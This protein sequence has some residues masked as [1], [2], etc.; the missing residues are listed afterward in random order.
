MNRSEANK[1]AS[2]WSGFHF[3]AY[4][5][6]VS[7]DVYNAK[8][9]RKNAKEIESKLSKNGFNIRELVLP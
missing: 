1:L 2:S 8:Q 6:D 3:D 9:A 5:F 4:Q 7:N